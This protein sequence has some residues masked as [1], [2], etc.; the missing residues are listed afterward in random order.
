MAEPRPRP[1]PGGA[2]RPRPSSPA[3]RAGG[4]PEIR[5]PSGGPGRAPIRAG[6]GGWCAIPAPVRWL[7]A[8]ASLV[9]LAIVIFALMFQWNWLR[10]PIS[11]YASAQMRRTVV[12]HGNLTAHPWSWTPSATA[13]DITVAQPAWAGRGQMAAVPRL[14]IALDLKA[15]LFSGKIILPRVDAERPDVAMV[16][17]ASGRNNWTF[18]P[19]T[20]TPQPLKLPPIRHFIIN[21]GHLVLN[22][23][24][25]RLHFV[26]QVSS[27]EQLAGW[28]RGRFTLIGQG[29]LNNTPFLARV[30]GGPLI[31]VDPDRAY[32]FHSDVHAGATHVIADGV[33]DHP[34]DLGDV[35][36]A[37][38]LSGP[39]LA[40]LY[41]LTG[42]A[43][44]STPPYDLA[45]DLRRDEARFDITHLH[46]RIGSSDI[47]GHLVAS[48]E[49]GR[50]DLT[51]VLASRR[52]KLAD[53][54]AVI[55]GA[56]R[57][58]LRGAIASPKQQAEAAKL[59]AERRILPDTPLDVSRLR[60]M[61]GDVRYQAQSVDAGRAPI[62]QV[63]MR[64]KLDHG[65]L[66]IDP[67]SLVLPQGALAGNIRVD[68][69]GATPTE[70]VDLQLS[71][72]RVE[73]L[74]RL[75]KGA[76]IEGDLEGRARLVSVGASVRAAAANADGTVVVAIPRGQMRQLLAE[77]MGVD[78]TKS[79][80][81]YLS[82]DNKPTPVRCA[83][84]EFQAHGGVLT[85]RRI[86]IDTGV[87][88]AEG[89][90]VIDLRNETMNLV[91]AG[92]PKH[93]R[94]IRIAAPITIKGRLGSPKVG[95]DVGKAAGQLGVGALLGALVSP[96]AAILPFVAPGT[97]KDADCGA[98]LAEAARGGAPV[99]AHG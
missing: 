1:A 17:D 90:G 25:R 37:L 62:R 56:P 4:R 81:L 99:S 46:G 45:G 73:Q 41:Y 22:D 82:K 53:L 95:V 24:R 86:L 20:A 10:G 3:R 80:F 67:L 72:A 23:A 31:N 6:I 47:A 52:L 78:V 79:L 84:A 60:Q 27:N 98:L 36:A 42:L 43:L 70:G 96:L 94:L 28:G 5:A 54:T 11:S 14:T 9:V 88:Q 50:K 55:G 61:D 87:V 8:L 97:A 12:I 71:H 92:K 75:A 30:L 76:P 85:A 34:F 13:E 57:S 64:V 44:P 48:E 33:I 26:G 91:I 68:A 58:V 66:T 18:G 89:R 65:L 63:L 2:P 69:R 83:V 49:G 59:T 16:R 29:T 32:P 74:L 39:D 77:L 38:R 93:F 40:D 35:K 15:L 51:G 7:G 19:P 21:D